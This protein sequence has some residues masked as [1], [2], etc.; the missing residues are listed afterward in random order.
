MSTW[1]L[2]PAVAG[3]RV[4]PGRPHATDRP[5]A[6]RGAGVEHGRRF[7][8]GGAELGVGADHARAHADHD[9]ISVLDGG[10]DGQSRRH[11]DRLPVA[12]EGVSGRDGGLDQAGSAHGDHQVGEGERQRGPVGHHVDD[13]GARSEL[14]ERGRH[15]RHLA[16]QRAGHHRDAAE[17]TARIDLLLGGAGVG[18]DAG[19]ADLHDVPRPRRG[20]GA[21]RQVPV[22]HVPTTG[23]E[24]EVD[25]GGVDHDLVTDGH[26]AD[27]AGE[28]VG[29]LAVDED[30]LQPLSLLEDLGD[31]PS[32]VRRHP[33]ILT[34]AER[35]TA[36]A[37]RRRERQR[38]AGTTATES[39][40]LSAAG[41]G[42][43]SEQPARLRRSRR[44]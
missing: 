26:G 22:D 25:R 17:I 21:S 41:V 42:S 43:A 3:S 35:T 15:D 36:H 38:A 34:D 28:R 23:A 33:A 4:G 44:P 18:L 5:A 20:P 27:L 37:G 6:E 19:V 14:E 24:P 8:R 31:D 9:E 16:V 29:A 7:D 40:A 13:P 2:A 39:Q 10:G 11:R 32:P 1:W 30:P 12:A